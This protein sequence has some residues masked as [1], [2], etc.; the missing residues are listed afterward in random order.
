[1]SGPGEWSK[2]RFREAS[3]SKRTTAPQ[4]FGSREGGPTVVKGRSHQAKRSEPDAPRGEIIGIRPHG[5]SAPKPR[6]ARRVSSR[7]S[8]AEPADRVTGGETEQTIESKTSRR[9]GCKDEHAFPER[10]AAI[11]GIVGPGLESG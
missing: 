7:M 5:N 1:M 2:A 10:C 4:G 8:G 3:D 11:G 6:R 9:A